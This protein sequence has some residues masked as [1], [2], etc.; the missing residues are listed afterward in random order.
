[1]SVAAITAHALALL[2]LN[3]V[4]VLLVVP[5]YEPRLNLEVCLS[6]SVSQDYG[7]SESGS[8][9]FLSA[10]QE[11]SS[12]SRL[13][14]P[15]ELREFVFPGV[16]MIMHS[17]FWVKHAAHLYR[18]NIDPLA[19]D[20]LLVYVESDGEV[21]YNESILW[22]CFASRLAPDSRVT[23]TAGV[24]TTKNWLFEPQYEYDGDIYDRVADEL[25]A[26]RAEGES[27]DCDR[28]VDEVFAQWFVTRCGELGVD[29]AERLRT[30]VVSAAHDSDVEEESYESV[31]SAF[32]ELVGGLVREFD[33]LRGQSNLAVITSTTRFAS[34]LLV[35]ENEDAVE[36]LADTSFR[37]TPEQST[38]LLRAVASI[39]HGRHFIRSVLFVIY[40]DPRRH[41]GSEF[42]REMRRI[43]D[44]V[45]DDA[46]AVIRT[47]S[48]LVDLRELPA[49]VLEDLD[50]TSYY[51]LL[52]FFMADGE[53]ISRT[54]LDTTDPV[55]TVGDVESYFESNRDRATE[56]Q[57]FLSRSEDGLQYL[58]RMLSEMSATESPRIHRFLT[59]LQDAIEEGTTPPQVLL[60]LLEANGTIEEEA[61]GSYRI[62]EYPSNTN[63]ASF[64]G[65]SPLKNWTETILISYE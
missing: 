15:K 17:L 35:P 57:D 29:L 27:Y 54:L 43:H 28:F 3:W 47:G 10:S 44:L 49:G 31:V 46:D 38:A 64:Y 62:R 19:Q 37:F 34:Q 24:K 33:S 21:F 18:Q 45:T 22:Y 11:T 16:G 4:R 5:N 58:P 53:T 9:Y 48:S 32:C 13:F 42:N 8:K 60:D 14:R 59:R 36:V 56:F 55:I 51:W 7:M 25:Q 39:E 30:D 2:S 63:S 65:I 52:N 61:S 20:R 41:S 6:D 12:R 26:M 50:E 40:L 1:M 23:L